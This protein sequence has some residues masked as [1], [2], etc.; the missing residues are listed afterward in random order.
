MKNKISL[1]NLVF[2]GLLITGCTQLQRSARIDE[3][4]SI[5]FTGGLAI[6]PEGNDIVTPVQFGLRYGWPATEN[7]W[8]F[9]TGLI[10]PWY[11][12]G[13]SWENYAELPRQFNFNMGI[14]LNLGYFPN[15]FHIFSYPFG[16]DIKSEFF[17]INRVGTSIIEPIVHD[18]EFWFYNVTPGIV[19]HLGEQVSFNFG[20]NHFF[21]PGDFGFSWFDETSVFTKDIA[22]IG[23]G[24]SLHRPQK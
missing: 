2:I 3:C 14:G 21:I 5:A 23:M 22:I 11:V 7:D 9:S 1:L 13:S 4:P 10:I 19:I 20:Y 8:G 17:L 12:G 18:N 6:D 16:D 24:L 15:F